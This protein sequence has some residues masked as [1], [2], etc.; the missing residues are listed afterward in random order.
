MMR[1]KFTKWEIICNYRKCGRIGI[2]DLEVK[3]RALLDKCIWR[4]ERENVSLWRDVIVEKTRSGPS[5][6]G[7]R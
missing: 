1:R 5:I 6:K 4:Y 2:T 3:N 7:V